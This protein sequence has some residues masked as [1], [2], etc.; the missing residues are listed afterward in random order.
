MLFDGVLGVLVPFPTVWLVVGVRPGVSVTGTGEGHAT[1]GRAWWALV[2]A[3]DVR[4][5]SP[6]R[7][8]MG[9]RAGCHRTVA[10][11]HVVRHT[12]DR[13]A[14]LLTRPVRVGSRRYGRACRYITGDGQAHVQPPA[15]KCRP[16]APTQTLLAC[17]SCQERLLPACSSLTAFA[18][19]TRVNVAVNSWRKRPVRTS[20]RTTL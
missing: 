12:L 2:V 1:L 10:V 16:C 5:T 18:R 3:A 8:S 20:W 11:R 14:Q 19:P 17:H 7:W 15:A 4:P 13:V 9:K 6:G